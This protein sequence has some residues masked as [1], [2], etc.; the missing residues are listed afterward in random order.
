M[1][2][3][4]MEIPKDAS[5]QK[6]FRDGIKEH[7]G[8]YFVI[9]KPADVNSSLALVSLVFPETSVEVTEVR[10]AMEQEL[11]H[12][13]NR[14]SVPVMVTAFDVTDRLI[15]FS[16]G[17]YE[18]H[19]MGYID[20]HTGGLVQKWGLFEEDETPS[21]QKDVGYLERVYQGVPFRL[22]GKV[23]EEVR[24]EARVRGRVIRFI[25]FFYVG[26][27]VL[28]ELIAL[29]VNWLGHVLAAVSIAVGSYK[30]GKAMGWLK[31]T[32]RDKEKAEKGQ[33]M[34]H[35]FYHCERNPEAFNR[36]KCENFERDAIE[37]THKESEAVR[38]SQRSGGSVK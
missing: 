6:V 17:P 19:L 26:G 27:A 1:Q 37:Q 31:P 11:K 10:R 7:R 3:P 16:E 33:K 18:S 30:L 22:Q 28:I 21:E 34:G 4:K 5:N 38:K 32:K 15:H 25:V 20:P 9:Y 24:R 29:G 14:F 36:L 12:W 8:S 35:Y 13:L 2:P 23:R